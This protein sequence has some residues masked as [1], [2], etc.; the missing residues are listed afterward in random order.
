MGIDVD[1]FEED[2]E[3]GFICPLC[4][5]VLESPVTVTCRHTFCSPCAQSAQ[6]RGIDCPKCS[7]ELK[8]EFKKVSSDLVDKLGK[9]TIRCEHYS[10]GCEAVVPFEK[11]PEHSAKDCV[12]RLVRCENKG[13]KAECPHRDLESHMEK[14]DYRL[15]ECKVCKICLPR[16]DMPAHQA[17]KRCFEQLNKR[18]MVT[19]ARRLSQELKDHR[20]EMLHQR[21]LTDQ[22][23]RRMVREHYSKDFVPPQRQRAMSAGPILIRSSIQARVGSAMV[24]PHYSRNLKSATLDSCRQC[25][26][27]FLSG[28]RPSAQR[29]T[30]SKVSSVVL[31]KKNK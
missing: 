14:C 26:N 29:H 5:K 24:V 4:S 1:R 27:R 18:R 21:H 23:E 2:V 31:K 12:F 28:R 16:K 11:L 3:E 8:G 22:E 15:V 30:H 20:V 25:S 6:K 19:S 17:I 9:L 10:S 7:A 13:C